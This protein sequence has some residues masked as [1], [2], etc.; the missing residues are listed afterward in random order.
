MNRFGWL[1]S[2]VTNIAG[3]LHRRPRPEDDSFPTVLLV[4]GPETAAQAASP[5]WRLLT[6][7]SLA[8]AERLLGENEVAVAL[9]DRDAPAVDWK[10]AVPALA[11]TSSRPCVVLLT[12]SEDSQLWERVTA[13]GGYDVLRKPVSAETLARA[14][15]AG[16]SHWRNARALE[17]AR[18][19]EPLRK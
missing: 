16:I 11:G 10:R 9:C 19:Q 2:I 14:I 3:P 4:A 18:V 17:A 12:N 6:T 5:D 8:E 1:N 15:R 13:A 7:S